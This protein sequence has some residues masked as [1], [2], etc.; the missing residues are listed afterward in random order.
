MF[1]I[2][3]LFSGGITI[4]SIFLECSSDTGVGFTIFSAILFPVI[5]PVASA[6]SWTTFMEAVF[7]DSNT[8]FVNLFSQICQI[9][10]LQMTKIYIP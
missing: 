5:F 7:A 1:N 4:S 10:F 3:C 6:V 9:D 8:V 2:S